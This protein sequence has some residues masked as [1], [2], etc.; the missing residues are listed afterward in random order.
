MADPTD[1]NDPTPE[2]NAPAASEQPP[3]AVLDPEPAPAPE[4]AAEPEPAAAAAT[5]E[6]PDPDPGS[7]PPPPELDLSSDDGIK[8]AA[9]RNPQL[10]AYLRKQKDDGKNE[11]A[12]AKETELRRASGAPDAVKRFTSQLFEKYGVTPSEGDAK[13][14]EFVTQQ[15]MGY[16]FAEF[17]E[18][19]PEVLLKG[20]DI[21]VAA[22]EEAVALR[23]SNDYDGMLRT[24][25]T[26]AAT[27]TVGKM[28]LA[29]VPEGS[30]LSKD[31]KAEATRI[32]GEELRAQ[33]IET[34][35]PTP[36]APPTPNG[37]PVGTRTHSAEGFDLQKPGVGVE[38]ARAALG[39]EVKPQ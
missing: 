19:I 18:R 27:D 16:V 8:A 33:G 5:T 22:R 9:E 31:L 14:T 11:G 24:Y 36:G 3:V 13:A 32:A 6:P 28:R 39:G 30:P 34:T 1:Q 4:P 15:A 23:E 2:Q 17:T 21:P 26:A 37:R 12:Q 35:P 29:D 20:Y 38:L 10:A 25:L 7:D